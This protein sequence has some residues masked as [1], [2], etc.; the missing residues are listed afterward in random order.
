[1]AFTPENAVKCFQDE[2]QSNLNPKARKMA[3]ILV[4]TEILESRALRGDSFL[5]W[6]LSGALAGSCPS[7]HEHR[8]RLEW[9]RQQLYLLW[10]SKA[11]SPTAGFVRGLLL[12]TRVPGRGNVPAAIAGAGR[13]SYFQRVRAVVWSLQQNFWSMSFNWELAGNTRPLSGLT[14]GTT[15]SVS[16]FKQGKMKEK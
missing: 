8:C 6:E 15:D 5:I 4:G 2:G 13:G 12:H 11:Q 9:T 16:K 7:S 3:W 14:S 1:M 10:S